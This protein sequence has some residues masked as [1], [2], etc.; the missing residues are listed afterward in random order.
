MDW[1]KKTVT[2]VEERPVGFKELSSS[3]N[4]E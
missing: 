1:Q 2:S 3:A 4:E